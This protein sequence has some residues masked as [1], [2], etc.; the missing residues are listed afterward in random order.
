MYGSIAKVQVAPENR[1]KVEAVL[2][3]WDREIKPSA[4]GA[5]D[6]YL[7]WPD[8]DGKTGYLVAMF[9][10]ESTYRRNAD[11][12]QQDAWYRRFRELLEADPEWIDGT[13]VSPTS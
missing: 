10:D 2:R 1:P 13:F 11:S 6:G 8:N 4:D 3:D 9:G 5:K 7:F 12:P